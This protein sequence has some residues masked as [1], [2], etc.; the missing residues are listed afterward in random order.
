MASM[1]IR[2]FVLP[3]VEA[4]EMSQSL[5]DIKNPN[6]TKVHDFKSRNDVMLNK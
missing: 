4:R 3:F 6:D 1:H 2:L 5:Q